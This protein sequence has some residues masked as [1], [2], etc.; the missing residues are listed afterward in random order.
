MD[1]MIGPV[2][3]IEAYFDRAQIIANCDGQ[4]LPTDPRGLTSLL[5]ESVSLINS[6]TT[7]IRIWL[8]FILS[9]RACRHTVHFLHSTGY[10]IAVSFGS[11]P[12]KSNHVHK[13]FSS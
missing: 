5:S 1:G 3:A 10:K 12:Q 9:V 2:E 7:P 4:Q 8:N 6:G 11:K 13:G